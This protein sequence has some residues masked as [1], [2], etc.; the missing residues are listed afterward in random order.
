M[1]VDE[2]IYSKNLLFKNL[3]KKYCLLHY[4]DWLYDPKI[5][6]YLEVKYNLPTYDELISRVARLNESSDQLLLGIF[7][8]DIHIGNIKLGPIDW[9]S[10][11]GTVGLI[12]GDIKH[13]G[14]GYAAES[15][16]IITNYAHNQLNL[17]NIYAGCIEAN[18]ASYK[19]FMKSGY[20]EVKRYT[21]CKKIGNEQ[22]RVI[23]MIHSAQTGIVV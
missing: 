18:I 21:R 1:V 15:I 8:N 9:V 6:Q 17:I 19:A 13:W 16:S 10:K 2:P 4:L 14:K 7:C 22:E 3:D 5:N 20:Q 23:S 12:I 11:S